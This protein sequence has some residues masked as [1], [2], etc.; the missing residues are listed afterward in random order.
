[1][2]KPENRSMN[3][4]LSQPVSALDGLIREL[5]VRLPASVGA[6]GLAQ[7]LTS[8]PVVENAGS[9]ETPNKRLKNLAARQN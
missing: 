7:A 2:T 9:R 6:S 5:C 1:M 4:V 3:T 8:S